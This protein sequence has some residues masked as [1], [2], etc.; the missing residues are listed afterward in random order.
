MH[1][2]A[3]RWDFKFCE[4]RANIVLLEGAIFLIEKA[5]YV[6]SA[7]RSLI[8]FKDL[9]AHGIHI[10]TMVMDYEEALELRQRIAIIATVYEGA[11]SLYEL[12]ITGG[13]SPYNGLKTSE[14][15]AS[16]VHQLQT[17]IS[18]EPVDSVFSTLPAKSRLWYSHM[19][20]LGTTMFR[21][22]ISIS[23]RHEVCQGDANKVRV[24]TACTQGKLIQ[25]PSRW[26]LSIKLPPLLHRLHGNIC[27]PITPASG[28]FKYFLVLVDAASTHFEVSLLSSRNIVFAKVLAILIKFRTHHLDFSV[29][30]LWMENAKEFKSQY[31]EDYCLA[32]GIELTLSVSYEHS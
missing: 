11:T 2:I 27:G 1:T 14:S 9:R 12:P 10:F 23:S 8:N 25:R 7:H 31:F 16:D 5:M 3:G 15:L 6:W 30:I 13:T 4:G 18:Q 19:D 20:H 17:E 22:M 28:P 32:T 26:K 21:R 29:K 24:C